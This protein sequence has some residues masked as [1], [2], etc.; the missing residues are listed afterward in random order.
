MAK[1]R[2]ITT[3]QRRAAVSRATL[4][5]AAAALVGTTAVPALAS[6][7]I[8]TS[9]GTNSVVE[10]ESSLAEESDSE[11]MDSA[12]TAIVQKEAAQADTAS[13][14]VVPDPTP[15]EPED[16]PTLPDPGPT[17]VDPLP[18]DPTPEPEP[19]PV[20]P[21]P[22]PVD[23][24]PVDPEPTP[25]PSPT[26]PEPG[27]VAPAPVPTPQPTNPS[28]PN[29]QQPAIPQENPGTS[30]KPNTVRPPALQPEAVT[31]DGTIKKPVSTPQRVTVMTP[32]GQIQQAVIPAGAASI[33]PYVADNAVLINSGLG[34][35][36]DSDA[37]FWALVTGSTLLAGAGAIATA[38]IQGRRAKA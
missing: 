4:G 27:P 22:T 11:S 17:P 18:V 33:T 8:D 37:Q 26:T 21:D 5:I 38:K 19:T 7:P 30:S 15:I 1:H 36:Q 35:G 14:A 25:D 28:K 9:V 13:T 3:H 12:P 32:S 34:A 6:E 20:D 29:T 23:P 10:V 24:T 31:T 16:F 2:A